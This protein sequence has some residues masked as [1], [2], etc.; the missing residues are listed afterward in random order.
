MRKLAQTLQDGR[1]PGPDMAA[2]ASALIASTD[3]VAEGSTAAVGNTAK[4]QAM[5]HVHPRLSS[6]Q[7]GTTGAGGLTSA[8]TFTRS[9]DA[10]PCAILTPINNPGVTCD[11]ASWVQDGNGKYVGAVV[12]AMKRTASTSTTGVTVAGIPVLNGLTTTTA[13]TP[14]SGCLIS[15]VML[16]QSGS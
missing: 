3:P 1:D 11:V 2:I 8:L 7:Y 13:D 15:V 14:I 9:F 4:A 6:A 16:A 12:R 5:G 10:M